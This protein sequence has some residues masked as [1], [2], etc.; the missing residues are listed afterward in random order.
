MSSCLNCLELANLENFTEE[1]KS[2]ISI[3]RKVLT[4][5]NILAILR[6]KNFQLII[7]WN[8]KIVNKKKGK[9]VID[10]FYEMLVIENRLLTFCKSS[11]H[12]WGLMAREKI[13]ADTMIIDY[14]GE[15]ISRLKGEQMEK[16]YKNVGKDC[17]L[18]TA[19]EETIVDAT[20]KGSIARFCNHSCQPTLYT[21][22]VKIGSQDRLVFFSKE[23]IDPGQELTYDYRFVPEEGKNRIPCRCGASKCRSFMN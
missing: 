16:M 14:R 4:S 2:N 17:Y 21:K 7:K 15:I 13:P 22:I 8:A 11:I 5:M 10:R 19:N 6:Y 23:D 20:N 18:F 9:T 3:K 1:I 12:G